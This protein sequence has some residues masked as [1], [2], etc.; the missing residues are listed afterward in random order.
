MRGVGMNMLKYV[1]WNSQIYFI[2]INSYYT[3]TYIYPLPNSTHLSAPLDSYNGW[4][5]AIDLRLGIA[6]LTSITLYMYICMHVWWFSP[7]QY[8]ES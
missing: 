5:E 2:L 7:F 1:V 6:H 8:P 3:V 4:S